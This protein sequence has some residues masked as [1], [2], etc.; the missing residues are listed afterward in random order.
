[1][2]QSMTVDED[3]VGLLDERTQLGRVVEGDGLDARRGTTDGTVRGQGD[4]N[5]AGEGPR[6]LPAA[7][8][9]TRHSLSDGVVG[10]HENA[11]GPRLREHLVE[12]ES[13][14]DGCHRLQVGLVVPAERLEGP[15]E[16]TEDVGVGAPPP[17]LHA[18]A[19]LH[20]LG[21]GADDVAHGFET[22]QRHTGD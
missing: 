19:L 4:G 22:C 14:R 12:A 2:L 20:E 7:H 5:A 3:D 18:P 10:E 6:D 8:A 15:P 9:R 21:E 11:P 1:M 16:L 17:S 13:L